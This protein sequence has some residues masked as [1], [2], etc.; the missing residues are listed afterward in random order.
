MSMSAEPGSIP[1][2]VRIR[3]DQTQTDWAE[4]CDDESLSDVA[5]PKLRDLYF[6]DRRKP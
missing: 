6:G 5:M 1:R 3:R 2:N 4:A